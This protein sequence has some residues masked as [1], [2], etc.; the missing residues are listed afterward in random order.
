MCVRNHPGFST[1]IALAFG[2]LSTL[3]N[4]QHREAMTMFPLRYTPSSV[5]RSAAVCTALTSALLSSTPALAQR[6]V[7]QGT[8]GTPGT[9]V[10]QYINPLDITG[11]ALGNLYVT[12]C[13]LHRIYKY[14]P[15]G[16]IVKTWGELGSASG[17]MN[18]PHGIALDGLGRVYVTE[19]I[20]RRI[21]VFDTDGNALFTFGQAGSGDGSFSNPRA[22]AYHPSGYVFVADDATNK[23]QKFTRDGVFVASFG[24]PGTGDAQFQRLMGIAVDAKG[25][26]LAVDR[27]AAKIKR[28]S[29]AG[30]YIDSFGVAGTAAG[31]LNGAAYIK[32]DKN[33]FIYV[34]EFV[35]G[36]GS[37]VSRIQKFSH[38]GEYLTGF[39]PQA[40][41]SSFMPMN[42]YIDINGNVFAADYG[43]QILYKFAPVYPTY[44]KASTLRSPVFAYNNG[45]DGQLQILPD[46][47]YLVANNGVPGYVTK[48]TP[49]GEAIWNVGIGSYVRGVAFDQQGNVF[50]NRAGSATILKYNADG[51]FQGSWNS[52]GTWNLR[53]MVDRYNTLWSTTHEGVINKW[54]TGGSY[55]GYFGSGVRGSGPYDFSGP[56]GL[57]FDHVD[58]VYVA[59]ADNRRLQKFDA[60]GSFLW[61]KNLPYTGWSPGAMVID[62]QSNL[63]VVDYNG[64][65]EVMDADG[66]VRTSIPNIPGVTASIALDAQ[67]RIHVFLV[68][69]DPRLEVWEPVYGDSSAPVT[70]A[71]VSPVQPPS[72]WHTSD[73]TVSLSATDD[74]SGIQSINWSENQGSTTSVAG[75]SATINVSVDG[76]HTIA[77]WAVDAA[78]NTEVSKSTTVRI[79]R[80]APVTTLTRSGG[81][82]TLASTDATS[83]VAKTYISINNAAAVE[84]T[85]PI[86]D[87][88]HTIRY[89][90]V[91]TAGNTEV[92][93]SDVINP[94]VAS[95]SVGQ[96]RV[97]G[98]VG[99]VATIAI[100]APAPVGGLT[101]ALAQSG[102]VLDMPTSLVIAE[103]ETSGVFEIDTLPVAT[104]TAVVVT[105]TGGGESASTV[106][107]IQAPMVSQL[108]LTPQSVTGGT[109]VTGLV[110]LGSPAP[111]GGASV[112]LA[113][114][115]L[116]ATVPTSVVI[117]AGQFS[118]P[119]T[120]TTRSVAVD[121]SAVLSATAFGTRVKTTL[122]ILGP[123][124]QSV[125]LAANTITS[126]TA[127]MATVM[128]TT[129]APT[130]GKVVILSSSS[131]NV[132]VP[133]SVTVLAGQTTATFLV[134][135]VAVT[136]QE[137][138]TITATTN[139]STGTA[140]LTL[141]IPPATLARV[142]LNPSTVYGVTTSTGTVTLT[143]PA[144]AGGAV[145]TLKSSAST[146][147]TVPVNVTVAPGATTAV[148]TVT[149]KSVTTTAPK[150]A[151]I[152][153]TYASITA[154]AV[155]T[156][157]R[158]STVASISLNPTSVKGGLTSTATV[159]LT[160][161]AP[162]GGL[163]IT[164]T[165]SQ[166]TVAGVPANVTVL[167][168]ATAAVFTIT[169][170]PQTLSKTSTISAKVGTTSKTATLTVTK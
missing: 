81:L 2:V 10:G 38:Q 29:S 51:V 129:A 40:N 54:T 158:A 147:A 121:S 64:K 95:L 165:S 168:G 137:T 19:Y 20:N 15:D 156:V 141:N 45:G 125:Q 23:I 87:T 97:S 133:A 49:T 112:S 21:Q 53:L 48:M 34:T 36:V 57:A 108:Q 91:D 153:A 24:G 154:S 146:T 155:L 18:Q 144:P 71:A 27:D 139:G 76:I 114:T 66:T 98:G 118:A 75:G 56:T 5:I 4:L 123:K 109:S 152:T 16:S 58:N 33:G 61:L 52:G 83:G 105:A 157:N 35:G 122:S 151:T 161:P 63:Y 44:Q 17:Q 69:N 30:Q 32:T 31:Q 12:D 110:L 59:D 159:T 25:N 70:T 100:D 117:A 26:I 167:E 73:V 93:H 80:V 102:N 39:K 60:S 170:L 50:A 116:N 131:V 160:S 163:V 107:M 169:T 134:S 92:A 62:K 127:L 135:S 14:G 74:F 11:D 111:A 77:Y 162:V 43:T 47:N 96:Q 119:F 9:G 126:G 86:A 85:A 8:I 88:V 37:A 79:D 6:Y 41:A 145:V 113:S 28:F 143:S 104:D 22:I 13:M 136:S 103:G 46:G 101:V 65:I 106:L 82:L 78:N 84:Y 132:T 138:A 55:I 7:L 1:D 128:L 124:V 148:F 99:L 166:L 130:G 89:W 68:G 115:S 3:V 150:T 149:S 120:V 72:G 90:S 142:S 140:N 42:P 67:E 94:A 164:T